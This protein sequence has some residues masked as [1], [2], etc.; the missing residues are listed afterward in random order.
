MFEEERHG[1]IDEAC[2]VFGIAGHSE[3]ANLAYL[4]LHALQHRGQES[5]GIVSRQGGKLHVQRHEGLV[6]EGFTEDV[7]DSLPGG[8]AIGHVRYSTTGESSIRN[9][10]PLTVFTKYGPL[11]LAHNGNLTNADTLRSELESLGS[12]FGTSTDTEVI[13]HLV[14]RS[15]AP[16]APSST[17]SK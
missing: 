10:Q 11:A 7:L 17:A 4:G 16:W 12:I 13:A 6:S 14:A 8:C 2:G 15:S 5:A 9:A 3:A 1:L